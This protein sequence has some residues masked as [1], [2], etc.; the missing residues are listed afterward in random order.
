MYSCFLKNDEI[1]TFILFLKRYIVSI[2]VYMT[3]KLNT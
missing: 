3:D 1:G 2:Y